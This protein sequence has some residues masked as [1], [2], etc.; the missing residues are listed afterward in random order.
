MDDVTERVRE[1]LARLEPSPGGYEKTVNRV[2]RRQRNRRIGAATLGLVLTASLAVGLWMVPARGPRP[3]PASS[4]QFAPGAITLPDSSFVPEGVL[5]VQ[6]GS[7]PEILRHGEAQSESLGSDLIPL[8]LSWDG[9]EVL[10]EAGDE[11]VSVILATG[12]RSVLVRAPKGEV[13]G[14]PARWSPDGAMVA[15]SV[16]ASDSAKN[17][18]CVFALPSRSTRCFPDAGHVYTFDWSPNDRDLVVAGPPA[19][20]LHIVDVNTGRIS[21][22]VAQEGSTPINRA[23]AQRGWGEAFQLVGPIWSPSGHYLAAL[24]NLRGSD[25]AYVP[26]IFT[27]AGHPVSF[28]RPSGESPEPLRWSPAGDLLAYTQGEAP[29]RITE[30]RLLD[31][32]SGGDRVLVSSGGKRYPT[33]TDL[34]WSPSG[35]W[36]AV[37]LWD[38]SGGEGN[39]SLRVLEVASPERLTQ[40]EIATGGVSRALVAW[41]R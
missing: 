41:R 38:P 11:L 30:A 13:F 7:G 39:L 9:S 21:T 1:E 25:L 40:A 5:L 2:R 19:E 35:G 37:A 34:V 17:T 8:D 16:G 18:L 26:V 27:P 20:P 31:P 6:T 10:A 28:G 33:V 22:L 14:A 29:Y 32:V 36:L 24:A 23:I 12:E 15:F 4:P 3:H